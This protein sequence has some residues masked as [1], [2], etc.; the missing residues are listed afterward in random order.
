MLTAALVTVLALGSPSALGQLEA[1]VQAL[2]EQLQA[3][4]EQLQARDGQLKDQAEQLAAAQEQLAAKGAV[5]GAPGGERPHRAPTFSTAPSA[6]GQ[7][8]DVAEVLIAL[9]RTV[10]LTAEHAKY[11]SYALPKLAAFA[12]APEGTKDLVL[13]RIAEDDP[14][15]FP[16]ARRQ[17]KQLNVKEGFVAAVSIGQ[18]T[19][20]DRCEDSCTDPLGFFKVVGDGIC[21]DPK[22]QPRPQLQDGSLGATEWADAIVCACGTDCRDCGRRM[23]TAQVPSPPPPPAPVQCTEESPCLFWSFSDTNVF[24]EAPKTCWGASFY[25]SA[26]ATCRGCLSASFSNS[27]TATC[28]KAEACESAKFSDDATAECSEQNACKQATFSGAASATCEDEA[29]PRATFNE[30]AHATCSGGESCRKAIFSDSTTVTCSGRYACI[31]A[32]FSANVTVICSATRACGDSFEGPTTNSRAYEAGPTFSGSATVT[33]SETHACVGA[34]FSGSTTVTCAS[35][36]A[37][38]R[39]RDGH[40]YFPLT[41]TFLDGACCQGNYCDGFPKC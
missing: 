7:V 11:L 1:K 21:Q 41:A 38:H 13:A 16:E 22:P 18:W 15:A 35:H 34:T 9:Q 28:A 30:N 6:N 4:T 20:E 36:N 37:C 8:V 26:S 3:L 25:D 33:C 17:L 12:T 14:S 27:A 40:R 29:C 32:T 24:C 39:Y 23:C 10:P 5:D 2:T 31:G 19:V